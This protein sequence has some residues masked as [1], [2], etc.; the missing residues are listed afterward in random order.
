MKERFVDEKINEEQQQFDFASRFHI[1]EERDFVDQG[2]KILKE[3]KNDKWCLIAL[4]VDHFDLFNRWYGEDNGLSLLEN[5]IYKLKLLP[6][7]YPRD[8]VAHIYKDNF[9]LM[10]LY[11]EKV[12]YDLYDELQSIIIDS[13]YSEGFAFSFGVATIDDDIDIDEGYDRAIIALGRVKSDPSHH[14]YFYNTKMHLLAEKEYEI[15][16]DFMRALKEDEI[17]FYLQPQCRISSRKIVGAEALA[18]WIKKDGTIIPPNDF[19]PILEK[20]GFITDLDIYLW[21]KVCYKISNW[22]Q[23]GHTAVPVSFNVSRFD[24]Y[25]MDI[26][27]HFLMLTDKYHLP[28]HLI[29]IE[30]TESAYIDSSLKVSELIKDLRENGFMVLM[31][32]FGS[33]YS[34]LNMLSTMEVD[35]IKL[36]ALFM[37]IDED[38]SKGIH[39]LE[40]VINMGKSIGL[41]IIVEGVENKKQKDFLESLGVRYSQ[42]FYFYKPMTTDDF[43]MIVQDENN[44]DTRGFIVK[45][46][47][48]FRVREFLDT[49]VYSDSMLN[50]ILGSVAIYELEGENV[51]IIRFNEQFYQ[52]VN[53]SDFHEKLIAI[54]NV[55]PEEDRPILLNLLQEA[56]DDRFNGAEGTLRFRKITGEL[57]SYKM[58]FFHIGQKGNNDLFYGKALNITELVDDMQKLSTISEFGD[59]NLVFVQEID[60]KWSFSLA[61]FTLHHLLDVSRDQL[62]DELNN[63]QMFH[64]FNN[65]EEAYY[66]INKLEEKKIHN[67]N[68]VYEYDLTDKDKNNHHIIVEA[69]CLIERA[70]NISYLFK[71]KIK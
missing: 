26:L 45:L 67:E 64:L 62:E 6:N 5:I 9:M 23:T 24:I 8:I 31:D 40:S 42:G 66:F 35:A 70:N 54:N 33:G 3:N 52:S 51:N 27:K 50:Q 71:F 57:T 15:L 37:N 10:T 22:M 55:M 63:G 17:T 18:R 39:I 28:H 61:S 34:S 25:K 29:K 41:P 4:D 59:E 65:A 12:I 2:N 58:R 47:D 69:I 53:V 16:S 56:K 46:N 49:N 19:I 20:L 43:E 44:I 11:D 48:Q 32:D 7:K 30:I 14:I 68:F 36:D 60:K 38:N 13:H 1:L 21:D